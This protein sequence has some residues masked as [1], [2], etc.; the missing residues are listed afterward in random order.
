VEIPDGVIDLIFKFTDQYPQYTHIAMFSDGT[1]GFTWNYCQNQEIAER[2]T[3]GMKNTEVIKI[4][5]GELHY[6]PFS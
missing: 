1:G 2:L 6:P 4:E 5:E 3:A